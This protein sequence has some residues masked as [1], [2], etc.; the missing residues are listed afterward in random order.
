MN[1][2]L[3]FP[4]G[5]F[6][7]MPQKYRAHNS[8]KKS[9]LLEFSKID[10]SA[11]DMILYDSL[12]LRFKRKLN[13]MLIFCKDTEFFEG[14][15]RYEC[16]AIYSVRHYVLSLSL[17]ILSGCDRVISDFVDGARRGNPGAIL[18]PLDP[19]PF[20]SKTTFIDNV[21]AGKNYEMTPI[22]GYRVRQSVGVLL[23][24]QYS[25][26]PQ[27]FKVYVNLNGR[28]TSEEMTP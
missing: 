16:M 9:F 2:S 8:K 24:K 22:S 11:L 15:R 6:N 5:L 25:I 4:T 3:A 27:G 14:Q 10:F 26:T 18:P 28:L 13:K 23:N 20:L 1:S 19:N 21:T 12:E 17:V 7:H